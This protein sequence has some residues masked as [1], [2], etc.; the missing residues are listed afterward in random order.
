MR[1]D[2]HV[3]VFLSIVLSLAK[4]WS[5]LRFLQAVGGS[6]PP[7]LLSSFCDFLFTSCNDSTILAYCLLRASKLRRHGDE[8]QPRR[9]CAQPPAARGESGRKL[10]GRAHR[11][12]RLRVSRPYRSPVVLYVTVSGPHQSR[13]SDFWPGWNFRVRQKVSNTVFSTNEAMS[14]F[15]VAKL[16]PEIS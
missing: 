16:E 14:L 10:P 2:D 9:S 7:P 3:C 4:T 15:F 5:I 12:D 11:Q 13:V 1:L 6:V 8:A